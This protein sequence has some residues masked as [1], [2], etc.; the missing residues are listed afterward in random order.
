MSQFCPLRITELQSIIGIYIFDFISHYGPCISNYKA[1][2]T[3]NDYP[4]S[5]PLP[6]FFILAIVGIKGSMGVRISKS[7]YILV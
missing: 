6:K 1:Q 2:S 7:L 4:F 5:G 3:L